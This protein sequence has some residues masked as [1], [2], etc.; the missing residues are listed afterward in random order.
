M[1]GRIPHSPL[2]EAE[3]LAR[4]AQ[5]GLGGDLLPLNLTAPERL[6]AQMDTPAVSPTGIALLNPT[7]WLFKALGILLV[8]AGAVAIKQPDLFPATELD[9]QIAVVLMAV[10]GYISPGARKSA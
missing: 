5:D 4:L 2:P 8:V 1:T 7:G 3:R 6:A 9:Q 10:L